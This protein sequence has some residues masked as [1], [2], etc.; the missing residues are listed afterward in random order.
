[1]PHTGIVRI[2]QISVRK[3]TSLFLIAGTKNAAGSAGGIDNS[4]V[5]GD[6]FP[7]LGKQLHVI[8]F[9]GMIDAVVDMLV[10]DDFAGALERGFDRG[11]LDQNVGTVTVFFNHAFDT[12]QV[13][14][15][16]G[17]TVYDFALMFG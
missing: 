2:R 3:R 5:F 11:E 17:K 16:A 14:D 13:A 4:K 6:R 7:E 15:R 8:V 12:L 9:Y 10:D 1:M